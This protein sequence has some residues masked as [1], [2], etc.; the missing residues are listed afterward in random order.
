MLDNISAEIKSEAKDYCVQLEQLEALEKDQYI[1]RRDGVKSY[2]I[3]L[4]IELLDVDVLNVA[5]EIKHLSLN[6][7]SSSMSKSCSQTQ[8]IV[9]LLDD[10]KLTSLFHR[11]VLVLSTMD[12]F[13]IKGKPKR[14]A[15]K[16]L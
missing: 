7:P 4:L 12:T 11:N 13:H 16:N 14:I 6:K 1:Y 10:P 3:Q 9:T 15:R 8:L 2:D 5:P